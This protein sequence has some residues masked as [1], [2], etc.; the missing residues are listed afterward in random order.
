MNKLSAELDTI[1]ENR[2]FRKLRGEVIESRKRWEKLVQENSFSRRTVKGERERSQLKVLYIVV[3][4]E[5]WEKMNKEMAALLSKITNAGYSGKK[6]PKCLWLP[7]VI[8]YPTKIRLKIYQAASIRKATVRQA[9]NS[10]EKYGYK[11]EPSS[12]KQYVTKSFT[13]RNYR[14]RATLGAKKPY[15]NFTEWAVCICHDKFSMPRL[16]KDRNKL[17]KTGLPFS[18]GI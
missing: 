5:W 1:A 9:K 13:G 15:L 18:K 12:S 2:R 6:K 14:L 17:I 10:S 11:I 16:R 3:A 7:T 8:E 4:G